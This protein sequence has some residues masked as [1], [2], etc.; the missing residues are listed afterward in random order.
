MSVNPWQFHDMTATL[1]CYP[2]HFRDLEERGLTGVNEISDALSISVSSTSS[3]NSGGSSNKRTFSP[4]SASVPFFTYL[5]TICEIGVRS[6]PFRFPGS[7]LPVSLVCTGGGGIGVCTRV[8][9]IVVDGAGAVRLVRKVCEAF[10]LNFR[11]LSQ[12]SLNG[13]P[14]LITVRSFWSRGRLLRSTTTLSPQSMRVR[15]VL[16]FKLSYTRD[17][18]CY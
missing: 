17:L 1:R 2:L 11:I 3:I 6:S 18:F 12:I 4:S 13:V 14:Q 9:C 7:T 15:S 5:V 10:E 8:V 16:G